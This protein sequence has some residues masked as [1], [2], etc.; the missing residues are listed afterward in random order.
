MSR[1]G[2]TGNPSDM[3]YAGPHRQTRRLWSGINAGSVV[4]HRP[5]GGR[6]VLLHLIRCPGEASNRSR[7]EAVVLAVAQREG[8]GTASGSASVL[9]CGW[10]RES[11]DRTFKY[12]VRSIDDI[13]RAIVPHFERFPLRGHEAK[14]CAAFV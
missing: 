11:K 14:S 10:I 12:E 3:Q 1:S 7:G 13:T 4:R 9:C 6:G 2:R 5:H 8:P